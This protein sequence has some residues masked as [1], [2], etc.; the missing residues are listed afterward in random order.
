VLPTLVSRC[1]P[2]RFHLAPSAVILQAVS[3]LV[4]PEQAAAITGMADGRIGWALACAKNDSLLQARQRLLTEITA[5]L[6]AGRP[7]ALR[8]AELLHQLALIDDEDDSKSKDRIVRR[9]L[10]N[11]LDITASWWRDLLIAEIGAREMR[12][13]VDFTHELDRC[14]G[15]LPA[16]KLQRGLQAI[17][18]TKRIIER[19]ANIDLALERMWMT[20][21]ADSA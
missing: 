16:E 9:N 17:V 18:E 11:L 19:N 7:A 20:V 1:R 14:A 2:V 15:R 3:A 5:L 4:S 6:S 8:L 13:N 10:P 21:L 12:I